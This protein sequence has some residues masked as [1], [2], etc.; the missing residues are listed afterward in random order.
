M[1]VVN[2]CSLTKNNLKKTISKA[3]GVSIEQLLPYF[4]VEK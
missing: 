2:F 4:L 3:T 1:S